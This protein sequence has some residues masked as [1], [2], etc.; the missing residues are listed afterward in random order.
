M[1]EKEKS[2]EGKTISFKI[3]KL[4]E[5]VWI[6]ST[7]F[8]LAASALLLVRQG[9]TCPTGSAVLSAGDAGAKTIE[10]INKNIIQTGA[11]TFV[12]ADD[13]GDMYRI[14]TDY[15]GNNIDVYVTKSG[16]L[17]FVSGDPYDMTTAVPT[18]TTQPKKT[19]DDIKKA[20]AAELDAYVVSYCPYG[21]QMQRILAEIVDNIPSLEGSIKV[22]YMGSV[23]GGKVT[24]MH[25][26]AEAQENLRQIC[27]REEQADKYWNYVSCFMKK[28]D[29]ADSCLSE[30]AVDTAKL[31]ACMADGGKGVGYAKA[32]FDLADSYGVG[33]SPTLILNGETVSEFD[34]GGRTADAVKT[35]LCCGFATKPA[36]CSA[37][38]DTAQAAAS[39][40]ESYSS[41]AT[42]AASSCG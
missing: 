10:Y 20:D 4:P 25:G 29:A 15:N 3:P 7:I 28:Q 42:S 6:A 1:A 21:L 41:G 9:G 22:R 30:A 39:F 8:L 26:D 40:S 14:T 18:A 37:E 27:I 24:A 11:A 13:M 17:L 5:R 35:L 33:G 19:C 31:G 12:S 23:V 16:K 36:A 2:D 32:D 38:L 34:F